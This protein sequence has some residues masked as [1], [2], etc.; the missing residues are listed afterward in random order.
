MVFHHARIFSENEFYIELG[1]YS[2]NY[3]W[4]VIQAGHPANQLQ[5]PRTSALEFGVA[6]EMDWLPWK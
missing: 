1:K 5:I 4:G 3:S 6:Q 2:N